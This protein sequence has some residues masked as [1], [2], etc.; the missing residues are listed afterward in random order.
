M[1]KKIRKNFIM[2]FS[3]I[4][5]AMLIL[6]GEF[7]LTP[8]TTAYAD[9]STPSNTLYWGLD[10]DT[11][12]LTL[13]SH[14]SEAATAEYTSL[15]NAWES[16]KD[17]IT[18]VVVDE[19]AYAPQSMGLWFKG[20][21]KLKTADLSGLDTSRVTYMHQLFYE[22]SALTSVNLPFNTSNVTAMNFM[23]YKCSGLTSLDLSSFY[24]ANVTTM[25]FM[26][27]TCSGLTSLD[28]SSFD[29]SNVT[30]AN[31]ILTYCDCLAE[32]STP[33][34]VGDVALPLP[35]QYWNGNTHKII[36][37]ISGAETNCLL[38]RHAGHSFGAWIDEI[39][40]NCTVTGTKAHKD[41]LTCNKHFDSD[42]KTE[43]TD[44]TIPV[45]GSHDWGEWTTTK[46][47]T[48]KEEGEERRICANDETHYETRM[49]PKLTPATPTPE[50]P[51]APAEETKSYWWLFW[52]LIPLA[53]GVGG[54]TY[55]IWVYKN[56]KKNNDDN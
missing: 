7:M 29:T 8:K 6:S 2:L 3:A 39:P 40:A 55:G 10:E 13:S 27:Y 5:A 23:F 31:G 35:S 32:I 50:T 42:G 24:T 41:C 12:V 34:I 26:F 51:S 46:E 15:S 49:L 38:V 47:A 18:S 43:I 28:L 36:N 4:I 54:V 19:Y 25:R 30:D 16:R 11:G 21:T 33:G 1:Q 37:S 14:Q 56:D 9:D 17:E 52:L 44:L 53:I 22:C 45:N 20:C 48:E